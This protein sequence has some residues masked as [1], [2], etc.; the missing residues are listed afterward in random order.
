MLQTMPGEG[1]SSYLPSIIIG[2]EAAKP[3]AP[4]VPDTRQKTS[5]TKRPAKGASIL[6]MHSFEEKWFTMPKQSSNIQTNEPGK[7]G[8]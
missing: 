2:C 3:I 4:D 8:K 5:A 1:G 7:G 6:S